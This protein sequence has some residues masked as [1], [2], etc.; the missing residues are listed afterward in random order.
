MSSN[1]IVAR[2]GCLVDRVNEHVITQRRTQRQVVCEGNEHTIENDTL[3]VLT[4]F[5]EIFVDPCPVDGTE[6][7]VEKVLHQSRL[8]TAG[9]L[10]RSRLVIT[11]IV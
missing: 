8:F 5:V 6:T 2:R 1:V 3:D 4:N 7:K 11:S 9:V 10:Q